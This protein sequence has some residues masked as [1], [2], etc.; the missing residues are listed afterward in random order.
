MAG[1]RSGYRVGAEATF[2]VAAGCL[3]CSKRVSPVRCTANAPSST[4][5]T[6]AART[7]TWRAWIRGGGGG[8]ALKRWGN[9]PPGGAGARGGAGGGGGGGGGSRGGGRAGGWGK[10]ESSGG[11]G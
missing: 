6:S 10:G 9:R 8:S 4:A 1:L 7:P 11:G 5:R 2:Q 3:A